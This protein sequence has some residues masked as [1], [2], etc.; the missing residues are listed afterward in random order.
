MSL[1]SDVDNPEEEGQ[2]PGWQRLNAASMRRIE[3]LAEQRVGQTLADTHVHVDEHQAEVCTFC[4]ISEPGYVPEISRP[5]ALPPESRRSNS[6]PV[7]SAT[8]SHRPYEVARPRAP[9]VLVF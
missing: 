3:H 7:F 2:N 6:L 1:N 8:L 5:A 4:A 9:P